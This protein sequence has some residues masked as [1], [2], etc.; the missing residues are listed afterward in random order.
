MATRGVRRS[1]LSADHLGRA[2]RG[3]DQEFESAC[4]DGVLYSQRG[5]ELSEL[6]IGQGRMGEFG[7]EGVREPV[8][9]FLI[10][11]IRYAPYDRFDLLRYPRSRAGF[12]RL[13]ADNRGFASGMA[14]NRVMSASCS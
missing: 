12:V 9:N 7:G 11:S 13:D 2:R 5:D 4:R 10:F 6:V 8:L 1:F 14:G 3:K